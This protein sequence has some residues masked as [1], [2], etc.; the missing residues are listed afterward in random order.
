MTL[1]HVIAE[2]PWSWQSAM[3]DDTFAQSP[4]AMQQRKCESVFTED[5]DSAVI[6]NSA[7]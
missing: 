7:H 5:F 1:H 2:G 4:C 6:G 3:S